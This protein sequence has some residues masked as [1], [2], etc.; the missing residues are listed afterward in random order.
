MYRSKID[1]TGDL[2]G[3]IYDDC[4]GS[5]HRPLVSVTWGGNQ[6]Q[7]TA[8]SAE[9]VNPYQTMP[10]GN[11]S[12]AKSFAG[13]P[14]ITSTHLVWDIKCRLVLLSLARDSAL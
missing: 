10:E 2:L 5:V 3:R 6:L 13:S 8:K 11:G 1:L 7:I 9:I 14:I 4:C 12:L